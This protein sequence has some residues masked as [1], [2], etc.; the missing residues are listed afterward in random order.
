M[1]NFS[2]ASFD[3]ICFSHLRWN[4]VYHRPQ[5][6]LTRFAKCLRVFYVEEPVFNASSDHYDIT[7]TPENVAIVVPHLEGNHK[8]PDVVIRQQELLQQLFNDE[9]INKYIFWY[10]TPNAI[11]ITDP[12]SPELSVYDCLDELAHLSPAP[13]EVHENEYK[14]LHT[15]DIV[16]TSGQS[17]YEAKKKFHNHIFSFPNSIDKKHFEASRSVKFD[18]PDQD[19]IPHPRIGFFGTIDERFDIELLTKVGQLKPSWHFVIIG[20]VVRI[21]PTTLPNMSNIHYL[22]Q[23]RYDELP[24]YIAG[25]DIAMTPYVHNETTRH[26][27]PTKTAEYLCAGKQVISTPITD[28]IR[29]FGN[30]E[31]V[32]I[33]GTAEE[34]IRVAEQQLALDDKDVCEW[35]LKVDACLFGQSWTKTWSEMMSIMGTAL[36]DKQAKTRVDYEVAPIENSDE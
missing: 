5:H 17:L 21:D 22:G 11:D 18:P 20:P 2:W 29:Y 13:D 26:T 10:C 7:L 6:L 24:H 16:F 33:A 1:S 31:L 8:R 4:F 14:L 3:M 25:W 23:K 28:V 35:V 15:A 32:R 36:A 19:A 9:K 27:N 34:F 30:S 12:F